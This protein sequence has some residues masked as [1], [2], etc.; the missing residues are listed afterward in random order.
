IGPFLITGILY[1]W[2]FRSMYQNDL[3]PLVYTSFMLG[4]TIALFLSFFINL[5]TKISIHSVGIAGCTT[6]LFLLYKTP[7]FDTLY[8]GNIQASVLLLGVLFILIWGIV[9][10]ARL[11][12]KAH[13][14]ADIYGGLMVGIASQLIAAQIVGVL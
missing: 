9:A 4:A 13:Q 10:V 8:W 3:V 14:P 2:A 5:F 7:N 11:Q 1:L 6:L 12:L